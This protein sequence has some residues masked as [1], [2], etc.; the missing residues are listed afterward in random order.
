MKL[1]ELQSRAHK[2]NVIDA[3]ETLKRECSKTIPIINKTPLYRGFDDSENAIKFGDSNAGNARASANTKNYYTLW[4]DDRWNKFP[5]RSRSFI[6]SSSEAYAGGYGSPALVIPFDSANVAICP[7]DDF[8]NSF[9]SNQ[10]PTLQ[11]LN[12]HADLF[13]QIYFNK[14]LNF[15]D[16]NSAEKLRKIFSKITDKSINEKIQILEL[17]EQE[18]TI[19]RMEKYFLDSKKHIQKKLEGGISLA[20]LYDKILT[21]NKFKFGSLESLS[22]LPYDR[23]VY[24]QG[25]GIFIGTNLK[26]N[27]QVQLLEFFKDYENIGEWISP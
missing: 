25:K 12:S 13:M 14:I 10:Y 7:S 26:E 15:S 16:L 2:F 9:E 8:W 22:K 3:I 23:E 6:C 17:K 5:K 27:D 20:D 19:S 21:P 11:S 4:V 18:G 1:F 24:F